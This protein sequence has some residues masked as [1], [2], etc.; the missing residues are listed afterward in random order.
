MGAPT[1]MEQTAQHHSRVEQRPF[2]GLAM[3]N[4]TRSGRLPVDRHVAARRNEPG[5]C[6]ILRANQTIMPQSREMLGRVPLRPAKKLR[7]A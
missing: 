7:K 5:V 1:Q 3:A 4:S 6:L 2:A